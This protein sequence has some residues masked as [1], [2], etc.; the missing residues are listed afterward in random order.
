VPESTVNSPAIFMKR[1]IVPVILPRPEPKPCSKKPVGT[2]PGRP[3][4][5][6]PTQLSGSFCL[7]QAYC[8]LLA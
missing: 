8:L 7:T 2:I 5:A 4:L 3:P 6:K 1:V